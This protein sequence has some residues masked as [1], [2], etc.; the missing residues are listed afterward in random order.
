LLNRRKR[1][2]GAARVEKK[3]LLV[4]DSVHATSLQ[5]AQARTSGP[6]VEGEKRMTDVMKE[7]LEQ[8]QY[9]TFFLANEECAVSILKV[10]EII[11]Y[12]TVT[13]VPK[14][15]AWARGVINLRG[16]V[17]PVVDLAAKFGMEQ[18]PGTKTTC[19]V[20]VETQFEGR[21]V[22]IGVIADSVSQVLDLSAGDIQPVP[23]FGTPVKIDYLL[24]MA[25]LGQ[26]FALLLDIDKVL[27]IDE[28]HGLSEVS[29]YLG[30]A[31]TDFRSGW[32]PSLPS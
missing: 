26:K 19:I 11:E 17:V 8:E 13:T 24:G 18:R 32:E 30:T 27:R 12:V 2:E 9:L 25:Q 1:Y 7:S 10:K 6:E 21:D 16:S 5:V 4:D 3:I 14:T 22:S 23:D 15:P 28:P 20:I 29:R 31:A